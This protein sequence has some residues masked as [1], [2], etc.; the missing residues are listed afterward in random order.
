MTEND[1][2]NPSINWNEVAKN[3]HNKLIMRERIVQELN[4]QYDC[5]DEYVRW[6]RDYPE[7][8]KEIARI[9]KIV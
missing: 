8:E 2:L 5:I 6:M 7:A 3:L 4:M 1:D 9:S